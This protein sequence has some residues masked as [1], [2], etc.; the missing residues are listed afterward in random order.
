MAWPPLR[1]AR[2]TAVPSCAMNQR[3]SRHRPVLWARVTQT[4]RLLGGAVPVAGSARELLVSG[5]CGVSFT[6]PRAWARFCPRWSTGRGPR[7]VAG[8]PRYPQ[9][10]GTTHP[11][12]CSVRGRGGISVM[13]SGLCP[14]N[15]TKG[16]RADPVPRYSLFFLHLCGSDPF[17]KAVG[18]ASSTL[19]GLGW[20]LR[21]R[22]RNLAPQDPTETLPP[23]IPKQGGPC[24]GPSG[25]RTR[26]PAGPRA[27]PLK[28][29]GDAHGGVS[30][31]RSVCSTVSALADPDARPAKNTPAE[32]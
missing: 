7:A 13:F 18:A 27:P 5:C 10:L 16:T 6:S 22:A 12:L 2:H 32:T 26:S 30:V 15:G 4:E 3:A 21:A 29:K 19:K 28:G 14:V 17:L 31:S 1:A 9:G 20:S 11:P 24:L 25:G 8:A 23:R